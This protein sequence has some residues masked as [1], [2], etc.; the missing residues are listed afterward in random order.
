VP[1]FPVDLKQLQAAIRLRQRPAR[2][3]TGLFI[4]EGRREIAALCESSF[5]AKELWICD[6][7]Y[8]S[9]LGLIEKAQLRFPGIVVYEL[10]KELYSTL[11][12]R[13]K[14]EGIVAVCEKQHPLL[15]E[16][17]SSPAL[18]LMADHIQKPGNLGTLLRTVEGFSLAG[19]IISDELDIFSLN[20]IRNSIGT[21]FNVPIYQPSTS[22]LVEWIERQKLVV[23]LADPEKG[24]ALKSI[25]FSSQ[26][27]MVFGAEHEGL[28][29]IW[30]TMPHECMTIPMRGRHDSLNVAVSAGICVYE[31]SRTWG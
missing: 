21:F 1:F 12:Y 18:F 15:P 2:Q 20:V 19:L 8:V 25:P 4:A 22:Q 11:G 9:L 17:I 31:W 28:S 16:T 13:D 10:T 6:Q 5:T 23:Y 24:V 7:H 30:G 14:N 26:A 27:L 29:S 3:A